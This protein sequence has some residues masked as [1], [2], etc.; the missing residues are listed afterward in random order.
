VTKAAF[1]AQTAIVA[2][3]DA[4]LGATERWNC[5]K[6]PALAAGACFLGAAA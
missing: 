5:G 1:I 6:T 4:A 2:E 3:T